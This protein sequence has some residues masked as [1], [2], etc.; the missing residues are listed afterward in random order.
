MLK[1]LKR[2]SVLS[3]RLKLAAGAICEHCGNAFPLSLLEIHVIDQTKKTEAGQ[4]ELQKELQVL[5]PECHRFFHSRPVEEYVQR[6]LVR[7][8]DRKVKIAMRQALG[9][10]PRTYIPPETGDPEAIFQGTLMSGA[11]DLCLNGG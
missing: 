6:E 7:Y 11:M 8:R 2:N 3:W 4:S 1:I 5:C 9:I 10:R